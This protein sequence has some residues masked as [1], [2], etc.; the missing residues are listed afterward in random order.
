MDAEQR[1]KQIL[2]CA[3]KLFASNGYYQTQISDIQ[4]AAGVARGTIYQYF[5]NKD[6]IFAS[7]IEDLFIEWKNVLAKIPEKDSEDY[8]SGIKFF[9]FKIKNTF[10]FF[11]DDPDYCNILLKIG[12]G[13]GENFDKI[14]RRFDLQ[15]VELTNDYLKAGIRQNRIKPDIDLELLSNLIGGALTRMAYYYGVTKKD[16]DPIDI[17]LLTERFVN[18]F[19][20]GI[21]VEKS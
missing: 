9:K 19:A 6:D 21:F 7:I 12:L 13:L 15:M 17:D 3:K 14:I 18:A 4:K 8:K 1:K 10:E 16:K 20:Y 5:K 11:A 2:E